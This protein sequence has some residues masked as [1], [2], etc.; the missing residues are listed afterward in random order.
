MRREV[1]DA[2]KKKSLR[3]EFVML[4]AALPLSVDRGSRR[5]TGPQAFLM[6]SQS[7]PPSAATHSL[8]NP[9]HPHTHTH[10]VTKAKFI[11]LGGEQ[12]IL[13]I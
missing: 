2:L 12:E 6:Q 7:E 10:N 3:L 8:T 13:T 9:P 1:G 4:T 11:V 5:F